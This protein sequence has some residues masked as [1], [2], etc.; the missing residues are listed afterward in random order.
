MD[1]NSVYEVG[2]GSGANLYLLKNRGIQVGGIDY[3]R[4]LVDT[5][6]KIVGGGIEY[7]E[8]LNISP[9][10][11]WDIVLSDSVFAYFPDEKYG[12]D[13]LKKMFQ[14]AGKMVI[15]SEVFNKSLEEECNRHRRAMV[16][17]YDVKYAG[18]DKIF[19]PKELFIDFAEKNNCSIWFSD[20]EN[21]YYWNSPYLYNCFIKKND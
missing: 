9:E 19:Y 1:V 11:Q 6:K 15:L 13:V 12:E 20:V 3:S 4:S 10:E 5:A 17:N 18:L 16:E 14:K 8:A 2:C 21:P 7:G